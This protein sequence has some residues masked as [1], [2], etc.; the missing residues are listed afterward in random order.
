MDNTP[1]QEVTQSVVLAS[2]TNLRQ[3]N[4]LIGSASVALSGC[5]LQARVDCKHDVVAL[6][7]LPATQ[8]AWLPLLRS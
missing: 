3:V 6:M 8:G 4:S 1:Q 5:Q 7:W 2:I